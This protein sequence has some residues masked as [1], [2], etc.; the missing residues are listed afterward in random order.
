M[1]AVMVQDDGFFD[2]NAVGIAEPLG[3]LKVPAAAIKMVIVPLLSFD[4]KGNRVGYGKG[5]Y[6]RF[7]TACNNSCIKVGFSHFEPVDIIEDVNQYDIALD[8]CITP[9]QIFTF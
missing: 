4:I 6:D 7:L 9:E 2:I 8:Y 5:N 3:S 1:Q